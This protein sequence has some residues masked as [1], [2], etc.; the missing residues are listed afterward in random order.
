[1]VKVDGQEAAVLQYMEDNGSI[2]GAQAWMELGVMR[3]ASV[4]FK[5]RRKGV[6]IITTQEESINR[7]GHRVAYARYSIVKEDR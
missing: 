3:L 7:Y 1:M 2:T 4:I 5:L 6:S